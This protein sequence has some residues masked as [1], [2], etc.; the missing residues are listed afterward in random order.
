MEEDHSVLVAS[1]LSS[2]LSLAFGLLE[3][4]FAVAEGQ[5]DRAEILLLS[6]PHG[7]DEL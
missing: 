6:E 3:C 5:L 1:L 2:F 4:A 7:S